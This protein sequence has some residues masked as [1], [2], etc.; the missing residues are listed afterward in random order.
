MFNIQES[1]VYLAPDYFMSVAVVVAMGVSSAGLAMAGTPAA[2]AA[3]VADRVGRVIAADRD[4][5]DIVLGVA[6]MACRAEAVLR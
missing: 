4:M 1:V 6:G 3:R 2:D 5:A